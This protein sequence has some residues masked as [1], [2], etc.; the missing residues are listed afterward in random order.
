METHL[1][2]WIKGT[3][4]GDDAESILRACVHCGFLQRDLSDVSDS[5]RRTRWSARTHLSDQAGARRRAA[6]AIDATASGSLPDLPQLRNDMSVRRALRAPRRH[7]P[8]GR[9]AACASQTVRRVAPQRA[10]LCAHTALDFRPG[11][12]H[13][14]R[15][16]R[17]LPTSL[18]QETGAV[19]RSRRDTAQHTY[20]QGDPAQRLRAASADPGRRCGDGAR[21]RYAWRAMRS[22]LPALAAAA[23]ST[24]TSMRT[25][26]RAK[27]RAATST[28]GGR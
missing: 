9:R 19:A 22:R 12:R 4:D 21:A 8:H 6:N 26:P 3:A 20:S 25:R 14:P 11:G 15:T 27:K 23:R 16:A 1:A 18:R 17:Q 2:D 10:A 5:R 24:I 13:R 28:R 7:R